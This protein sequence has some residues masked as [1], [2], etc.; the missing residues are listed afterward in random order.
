MSREKKNLWKNHYQAH[1]NILSLLF[2]QMF[3]LLCNLHTQRG[4]KMQ[5]IW[6]GPLEKLILRGKEG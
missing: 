2:P 6:N 4:V 5:N 3:L 1:T